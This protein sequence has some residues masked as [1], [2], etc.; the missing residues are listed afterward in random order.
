MTALLEYLNCGNQAIQQSC[1]K[2]ALNCSNTL[3]QNCLSTDQD[4]TLHHL[5][6]HLFY[7]YQEILAATKKIIEDDL[8]YNTHYSDTF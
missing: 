4:K 3:I 6:M 7:R 5:L 2:D 1:V 8:R